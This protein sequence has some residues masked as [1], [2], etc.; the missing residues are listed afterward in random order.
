[1]P[2]VRGTVCGRRR[3]GRAVSR[4]RPG[5]RP[6]RPGPREDVR[7]RGTARGLHRTVLGQLA[8]GCGALKRGKRS[9]ERP[10]GGGLANV[11]IRFRDAYVGAVSVDVAMR[12]FG[13]AMSAWRSS[14]SARSTL[15]AS[16]GA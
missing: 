1:W 13:F 10:D 14:A 6:A 12:T 16:L 4:G 9:D 3:P 15:P 7:G 8:V 11:W 2:R 5:L